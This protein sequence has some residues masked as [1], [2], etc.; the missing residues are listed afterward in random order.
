MLIFVWSPGVIFLLRHEL[1]S[2]VTVDGGWGSGGS[3]QFATLWRINNGP[4]RRYGMASDIY[5]CWSV[6]ARN[7]RLTLYRRLI[8]P[9][10]PWTPLSSSSSY[11]LFSIWIPL[12]LVSEIQCAA[13]RKR[14]SGLSATSGWQN[15]RRNVLCFISPFYN[16]TETEPGALREVYPRLSQK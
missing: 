7:V 14:S 11:T 1:V 13:I 16:F 2:A 10:F 9:C 8:R 6:D 3:F 4:R 15:C 5:S 12:S